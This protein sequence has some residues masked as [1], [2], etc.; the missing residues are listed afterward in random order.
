MKILLSN[1]DGILASG[2]QMLYNLL[3]ELGHE[4][5]IVAPD[6]QYSGTS[7][8]ITLGTP[9]IPKNVIIKANFGNSYQCSC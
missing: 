2:L 8:T 6:R 4:I 1:D 5:R 3:Q 9:L 7:H